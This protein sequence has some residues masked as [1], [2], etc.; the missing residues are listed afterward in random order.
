MYGVYRVI[1]HIS[2]QM[3]CSHSPNACIYNVYPSTC[4]YMAIPIMS[5][6]EGSKGNYEEKAQSQDDYIALGKA[7]RA[8]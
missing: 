4:T 8:E 2:M 1:T 3:I 6:E 5:V 7:T